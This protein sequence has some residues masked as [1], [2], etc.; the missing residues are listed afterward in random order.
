V[1]DGLA[2]GL[3]LP[4]RIAFGRGA[5][6][7]VGATAASF[8]SGAALITGRSFGAGP[9][10]AE[11]EGLL[12]AA[13]VGIVVRIVAAGEP[14]SDA[15][16]DAAARLGESGA[17]VL[18][19]VGGGS[20]IDL[21]KAAALLPDAD[22]LSGYLAGGVRVEAP[23]GLPVIALPTTAGSGSEVSHAAIVMD[24]SAGRKRG[25]RGPG[26]AARVAVVDPDLLDD[27]PPAVAASSG[28]D[29]VAHAIETAA[30]AAATPHVVALAGVALE[31]LLRAVPRTLGP[32][33][34]AAD[35]DDAAYAALLMG[36]NLAA[37]T[38]CLPHRL[39][40]PLGART[41]CGH[42]E[43]VAALMPAWLARTAEIAPERLARVAV[44]AGIAARD[45]PAALAAKRLGA[46][47]ADHLD[48]TGMRR[49][50]AGF[51][52][53]IADLDGLVD[54]VEGSLA[55]DPGP[56]TPRDLR[57]LYLASM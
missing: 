9:R 48:A 33:V 5:R 11:L 54:A 10:A 27:L 29:A 1:T 14:D 35:R 4:T 23:I 47:I 51:G 55:N 8:G 16:L 43:G 46:R 24:R 44:A 6:S 41:G 7:E 26:V 12:A 39:Q 3:Q 2:F 50:L 34:E 42:A 31:R 49:G 18:I 57:A 32:D 53:A 28:F 25:I 45:E 52:V 22:R 20:A 13:G 21:A 17:A 40:Y 38:T 19:A 37:S 56:T 15:V 30:S 36:I